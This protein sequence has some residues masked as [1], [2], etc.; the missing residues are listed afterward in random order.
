MALPKRSVVH[1]IVDRTSLRHVVNHRSTHSQLPSN[2]RELLRVPART[3][4]AHAAITAAQLECPAQKEELASSKRL[5]RPAQMCGTSLPNSCQCMKR[6][7]MRQKYFHRTFHHA[8][9]SLR[10][11]RRDCG[12]GLKLASQ[13]LQSSV[14]S[15]G[16]NSHA[17]PIGS[18]AAIEYLRVAFSRFSLAR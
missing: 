7:Q 10:V 11:C 5:E 4:W 12:V 9:S 6:S 15:S 3:T 14:K 1:I 13:S 16:S 17:M 8:F 18:F 2:F